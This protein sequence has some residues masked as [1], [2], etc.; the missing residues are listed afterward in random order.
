MVRGVDVRRLRYFVAVAEELHFGRAAARLH[1][2]VP[3]LS[4][5]IRELEHELG[6]ALF[7]R[8]SRKVA[9]TAAG[10]RLLVDARDVLR[11]MDR[12]DAAAAALASV[13][14]TS[15]VGYC[16]GSEDGMMRT[17]RAFRAEHPDAVIRPDGLTSLLILDGLCAGRVAVGIVRGPVIEPGRLASVPLARVPVDHVAVPP[18]HRLASQAVVEARDL[19]DEPVLVVERSDAPTAHDEIESYCA[20]MGAGPRWVTHAAVQVERVLDL[21][22]LGTGIGW[23]NSWQAARAGSRHD[24]VVRPLRPVGLYDDFRIAWRAGDPSPVTAA[25]VRVA[26]ETC[27]S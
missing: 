18:D 21:V 1:I 15:T 25:F 10:E 17:L 16:H 12:F 9:L 23:L 14:A 20:A 19:D 22:A 7:E 11:A 8:T 13:P 2:S 4:Q 24:V 27:G 26:L 6:L 5:R 3:P